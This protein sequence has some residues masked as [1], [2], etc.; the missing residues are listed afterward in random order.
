MA[1]I[2]E[3]M[4][5]LISTMKTDSINIIKYSTNHKEEWDNYCDEISYSTILH[6]RISL[7]CRQI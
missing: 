6:R 7:S 5:F 4:E 3:K 1:M 2:L